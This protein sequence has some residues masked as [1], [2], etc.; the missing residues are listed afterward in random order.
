MRNI[1]HTKCPAVNCFCCEI[2]TVSQFFGNNLVARAALATLTLIS[3]PFMYYAGQQPEFDRLL[4][5]RSESFK[6]IDLHAFGFTLELVP[7]Y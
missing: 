7:A 6:C 2:C 4:S 3:D 1:V 5:D